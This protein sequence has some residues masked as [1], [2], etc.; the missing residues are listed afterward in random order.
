[1]GLAPDEARRR[2]MATSGRAVVFSGLAVAEAFLRPMTWAE[3][4]PAAAGFFRTLRTPGDGEQLALAEDP[5]T[6]R[7]DVGQLEQI[8]MNLAV[9]IASFEATLFN[10]SYDDLR[11]QELPGAPGQPVILGNGYRALARAPRFVVVKQ[12]PEG[13]CS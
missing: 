12:T 3:Y 13:G 4:P 6:A 1:M 11:S 10:H 8:L 5:L 2:A 7:I 9:A